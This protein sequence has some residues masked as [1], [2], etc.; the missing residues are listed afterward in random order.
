M[1]DH[2]RAVVVEPAAERRLDAELVHQRDRDGHAL[3]V[4]G[5]DAVHQVLAAFTK[6]AERVEGRRP[7]LVRLRVAVR[8]RLLPPGLDT[9]RVEDR[10][11]A[12]AIAISER[13]QH[14][15]VDDG[16]DGRRRPDADGQR[17]RGEQRDGP[18]AL[19]RSPCLGERQRQ[20]LDAWQPA[21]LAM[22]RL[23]GTQP[24]QLQDG[25]AAR[26]VRRHA[27]LLVSLCQ[28]VEMGGELL[29]Q[30]QVERTL[31]EDRHET[32][33]RFLRVP[34][35]RV[36]PPPRVASTRPITVVRRVQLVVSSASAFSPARVSE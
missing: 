20:P 5:L 14:H 30:L 17:E 25:L 18:G 3:H 28:Q 6:P 15:A 29:V 35:H 12:V 36:A 21:R 10:H 11:E 13:L 2:R 22:Q 27:A 8:Q 26:L 31:S 9:V 34:R 1:R 7:L 16:V 4:K 23:R 32:G 19:P 33:Q 24:A